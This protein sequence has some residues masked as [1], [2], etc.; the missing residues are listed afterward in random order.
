MRK[1]NKRVKN[2]QETHSSVGNALTSSLLEKPGEEKKQQ[3]PVI[4]I[5]DTSTGTTYKNWD[6]T[7]TCIVQ[8]NALVVNRDNSIKFCWLIV[9]V[10][11]I[12]TMHC[13]AP[14]HTINYIFCVLSSFA[15]SF[16]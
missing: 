15:A 13:D 4:W 10:E 12:C 1:P 8:W 3:K 11:N 5:D 16:K 7:A 6:W 14:T 9:P 2:P